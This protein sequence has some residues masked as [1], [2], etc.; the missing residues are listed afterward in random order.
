[1]STIPSKTMQNLWDLIN[2]IDKSDENIDNNIS[3]MLIACKTMLEKLDDVDLILKSN[4]IQYFTKF[5]Q[6]K[7]K[8]SQDINNIFDFFN[9]TYYPDVMDKLNTIDLDVNHLNSKLKDIESEMSSQSFKLGSIESTLL[10]HG[11]KLDEIL[12]KIIITP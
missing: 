2:S 4:F 1:M 5:E 9:D 11:F 8:I 7:D 3:D 10:S 12:A 6:P